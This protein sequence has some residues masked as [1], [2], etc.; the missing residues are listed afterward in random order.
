M[1]KHDG[2]N[3]VTTLRVISQSDWLVVNKTTDRH[4][5]LTTVE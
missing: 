2:N 1:K 4:T 3:C 5:V